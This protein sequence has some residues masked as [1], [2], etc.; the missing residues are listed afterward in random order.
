MMADPT[1]FESAAE[2]FSDWDSC[3]SASAE[4][5]AMEELAQVSWARQLLQ[6]L[7]VAQTSGHGQQQRAYLWEARVA[8][9]IHRLGYEAQYE[10]RAGE[11][12]QSIDFRV[13]S[14]PEL[15]IEAI[16]VRNS[17]ASKRAGWSNEM[18]GITTFGVALN[19]TNLDQ[20]QTT[21]GEMVRVVELLAGKAEKFPAPRPGIYQ[22]IVADIRGY[23]IGSI[24][25]DDCAQIALGPGAVKFDANR[26]F[27]RGDP[28]RGIF[29]SG[30]SHPS[31][32]RARQKIHGIGLFCGRNVGSPDVL[33]TRVCVH[34]ANSFLITDQQEL[35]LI[36]SL[37]DGNQPE[38]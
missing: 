8:L 29:D 31:A 35:D 14:R 9:S 4:G 1:D 36:G 13:M 21:A 3:D 26:A 25:L 22:L 23:N 10:Y 2:F 27:F 5:V 30:N 6:N 33:S 12:E 17:Q 32:I 20:R 34:Q 18:P 11:G 38:R 37:L 24:D 16:A 7:K 15:L 28:V 19:S